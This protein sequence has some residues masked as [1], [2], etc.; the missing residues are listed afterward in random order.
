MKNLFYPVLWTVA[1]FLGSQILAIPVVTLASINGIDQTSEYMT[2]VLLFCF[3]LIIIGAIIINKYRHKNDI[4]ALGFQKNKFVSKYS[5]GF[6]IGILLLFFIIVASLIVNSIQ[7]NFNQDFNGIILFMF[8]LGFLIQGLAEEVLFRGYLQ[9]RLKTNFGLI[10]TLVIQGILFALFHGANPGVT[11][12]GVF[13]IFLFAVFLGIIFYYTQNIWIVGGIHSAWN[14][15]LGPII[16]IEVSGMKIS[17]SLFNSSMN[18]PT[19]LTG[20]NFGLEASILTT[21]ILIIGI[22]FAYFKFQVSKNKKDL[23]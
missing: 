12:L 8:L 5:I 22:I 2:I 10:T 15:V 23:S 7:I 1:I 17:T 6:L 19:W 18:G 9:N 3:V 20:G 14:F 13:N 16:G 4:K 11:F 21:I